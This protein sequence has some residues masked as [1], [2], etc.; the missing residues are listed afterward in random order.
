MQFN[1]DS[2]LITK[3][4]AKYSQQTTTT[5]FSKETSAW[6]L[7]PY[8]RSYRIRSQLLRDQGRNDEANEVAKKA[9]ELKPFSHQDWHDLG[10][11]YHQLGNHEKAL[12]KYTAALKINPTCSG[13]WISKGCSLIKM[14]RNYSGKKS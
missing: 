14:G 9:L 10:D 1:E 5:L 13:A 3:I 12:K 4:I 8:I 7:S 11:I 2:S 6:G